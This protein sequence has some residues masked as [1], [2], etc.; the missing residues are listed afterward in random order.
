MTEALVGL[1]LSNLLL[2]AAI[3]LVAYAVHRRGRY[4][5]LA[6]LLWVLTLIA[7]VAP[8][9]LTLM[10]PALPQAAAA[11]SSA[12]SAPAS[13]AEAGFALGASL[14]ANLPTV[15][16]AAWVAGSL[17]FFVASAQRIIR[18][19]ILLRRSC[20]PAPAGIRHIAASVAYELDLGTV[21]SIHVSAARLA[22]MTW[23]SGGRVRVVLPE[24]LLTEVDDAQ[25]RWILA[26]ELAHI[27]R[28]DHLVRWLEWLASM[29]FWWNPVVWWARRNLRRDEE[30]ACDALVLRHLQG[31]PR[32]YARTLLT[33]V[34]V[35][36]VPD[37]PAPA[38]ATGL[39]AARSLEHRLTRIVSPGRDARTPRAVAAGSVAVALLLMSVGVG[40][41]EAHAPVRTPVITPATAPSAAPLAADPLVDVS[42]ATPDAVLS[43]LG[44]IDAAASTLRVSAEIG[45]DGVFKGT[46]GPDLVTGTEADETF[47]GYAGADTI[48]GGPGRDTIDAGDGADTIRGG[49]GADTL[50]GGHGRDTI[51]GGAGADVINGGAGADVIQGG[52][53]RDTVSA[54]P[55]D[56]IVRVWADGTPDVVDCGGGDDKAVIGS[57]DTA[58]RCE[59]VVVRDPS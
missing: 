53:G 25:L 33:V 12:A 37:R 5:A 19:G 14:A 35:M 26:H 49:D 39:D 2:S 9:L 47:K 59:T 30:D 55:G 6:H 57:T 11:T 22:P 48:G 18:F 16:L 36:A 52:A 42:A 50:N 41:G 43:S 21:P 58:T 51:G 46:S 34:E 17:V 54:G 7:A 38:L 1:G 29:A 15:L 20:R 23:W 10:L 13:I 27:K 56:D 45:E 8:P 31:Q 28:R 3:G 32:A 44:A 40:V 24:A 4:P